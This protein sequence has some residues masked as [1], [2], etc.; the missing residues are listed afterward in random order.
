MAQNKGYLTAKTN[1][2]SDEAYTPAYAVEPLLK[3]IDKNW[4]IWCPFDEADS[5][6]VKQFQANG[7]KVIYS[8]IDTGENFFFYEPNEDYDVIISNP[9]FSVKDDILKRLNELGKPYAMLLPLP[10]LQ[11]QKRFDY[12]QNSEVLIFD[13][14]VNFYRDK[15]KKEVQKGV[16]F[17]S[18]YI[19][20]N[21]LPEKLI[22]EKL[23][24]PTAKSKEN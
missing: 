2:E 22:F 20:K 9:P 13:K 15:A 6:Y 1:Q 23:N 10:T 17:A 11:G 24:I 3:Y 7:N 16:S 14:R 5:E 12:L 4:T 8:H 21:F 19:C 18:I